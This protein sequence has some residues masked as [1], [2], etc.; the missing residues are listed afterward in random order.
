MSERLRS[1]SRKPMGSARAGSN[2]VAVGFGTELKSGGRHGMRGV[3]NREDGSLAERS[4]AL[5]SGASP[6]G[7]GFE[8]HCCHHFSLPQHSFAHLTCA[9]RLD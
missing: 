1:W 9:N 8:S 5:A 2:P 7:R 6:K 3:G 4:K